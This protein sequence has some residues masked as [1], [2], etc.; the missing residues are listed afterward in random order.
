LPW[1]L[2][3]PW[4]YF[5]II[6]CF[7][8]I[9]VA[10]IVFLLP[11]CGVSLPRPGSKAALKWRIGV[12]SV[13]CVLAA[14]FFALMPRS[15]SVIHSQLIGAIHETQTS[16]SSTAYPHRGAELNFIIVV[17]NDRGDAY[18]SASGDVEIIYPARDFDPVINSDDGKVLR[19]MKAK[20][21]VKEARSRGVKSDEAPRIYSQQD[22]TFEV[23]TGIIKNERLV[24]E[25]AVGKRPDLIAICYLDVL[26][27]NDFGETRI[28]FCIWTQGA[29]GSGMHL[30]A[31]N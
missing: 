23:S 2:L 6:V 31:G 5:F 3:V 20:V 22:G 18:L 8:C 30:C 27:R 28:P 14:F 7:S 13:A 24:R 29:R 17:K 10:V 12:A 1:L 25:F 15:L 26:V 4:F 21:K 19:M 9:V 11:F 16:L